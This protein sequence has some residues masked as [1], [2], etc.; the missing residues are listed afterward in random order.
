[1]RDVGQHRV[2]PQVLDAEGQGIQEVS[3]DLCR[4]PTSELLLGIVKTS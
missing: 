2:G 1:M 3:D 4:L